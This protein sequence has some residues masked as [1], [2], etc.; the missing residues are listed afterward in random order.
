MPPSAPTDVYYPWFHPSREIPVAAGT[1]TYYVTGSSISGTGH[2]FWYAGM[3]A[4]FIAN[5]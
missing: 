5:P 2:Q 4:T 3:E 1:Y